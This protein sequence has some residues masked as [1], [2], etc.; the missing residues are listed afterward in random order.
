MISKEHCG[1]NNDDD[2]AKTFDNKKRLHQLYFNLS[3][4]SS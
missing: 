4:A 2:D 3:W 1:D